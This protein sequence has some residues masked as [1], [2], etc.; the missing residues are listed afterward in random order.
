M[1]LGWMNIILK[2]TSLRSRQALL[3]CCPNGTQRTKYATFLCTCRSTLAVARFRLDTRVKS[4]GSCELDHAPNSPVSVHEY[5]QRLSFVNLA[6]KGQVGIGT[7]VDR[8]CSSRFG[9]CPPPGRFERHCVHGGTSVFPSE[10]HGM[11]RAA[12]WPTLV[13]GSA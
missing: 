12:Q 5:A 13:C 8:Q 4:D 10:P 3:W 7:V 9:R 11:S 2:R 1:Q 6:W